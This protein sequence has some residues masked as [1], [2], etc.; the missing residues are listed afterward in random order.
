MTEGM[1]G[2]LGGLRLI[3]WMRAALLGAALLAAAAGMEVEVRADA[4]VSLN[5]R[6]YARLIDL[7]VDLAQE[8]QGIE[9]KRWILAAPP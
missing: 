4:F 8:R 3:S 7:E 5:G 2:M 9:A 6:A 1:A